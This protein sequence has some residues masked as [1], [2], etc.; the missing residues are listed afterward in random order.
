MRV[1][2]SL[3]IMQELMRMAT[4]QPRGPYKRKCGHDHPVGEYCRS[5]PSHLRQPGSLR[6]R[7]TNRNTVK[8]PE[9]EAG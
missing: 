8:T 6:K 7:R 2:T 4:A 5:N 9:V 1:Y 3:Q